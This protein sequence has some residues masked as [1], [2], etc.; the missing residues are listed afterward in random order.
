MPSSKHACFFMYSA[1]ESE[2]EEEEEEEDPY[3]YIC[4]L[5]EQE[6]LFF[7]N[8]AYGPFLNFYYKQPNTSAWNN[9]QK[10]RL[11]HALHTFLDADTL[12]RMC[13]KKDFIEDGLFR[14]DVEGKGNMHLTDDDIKRLVFHARQWCLLHKTKCVD[15]VLFCIVQ[16]SCI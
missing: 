5:N 13:P 3:D 4:W 16:F 11:R 7:Q 1:S 6:L 2:S 15:W 12:D 10:I 14:L 9:P 8:I